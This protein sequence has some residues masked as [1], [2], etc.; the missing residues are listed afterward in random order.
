[1]FKRYK[2]EVENQKEKKIKILRSDRGGEYF[3]NEFDSFCGEHGIIHQKTA[4]YTP[5]QNGLA[6]RKNRTLTNM[7]NSMLINSNLL[8]DL[9][10][11]ALLTAC[12]LHNR[13]PSM[14]THVSPYEVWKNRKP[15]LDYLRVWG[16]L[17]FYRIHDP[18]SSKLGARGIK[19]VFIGYAENSKAYRLLDLN[20]NVVI[21]SRDV[22]FIEN[23]IYKDSCVELDANPDTSTR[24]IPRPPI[25]N[26]RN[27]PETE[28]EPRRS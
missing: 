22:E 11:E 19:S 18:K 6:E 21:E 7:I 13:I 15:N 8:N 10:G 2:A 16:C 25:N 24:L 28:I 9:W 23:K 26:K 20:S 3:P 4:P 14:K 5:Q 27:E 12:H 1:M 17:A